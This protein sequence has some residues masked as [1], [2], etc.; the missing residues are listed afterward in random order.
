MTNELLFVN[1]QDLIDIANEIRTQTKTEEKLVFPDDFISAVQKISTSSFNLNVCYES[2]QP[3]DPANNTIWLNPVR[4]VTSWVISA[5]EPTSPNEGDIWIHTMVAGGVEI[6]ILSDNALIIQITKASQYVDNAWN[7]IDMHIY[8]NG[9]WNDM[10][11][12]LIIG[13]DTCDPITGGWESVS[14]QISSVGTA[15]NAPTITIY[16]DRI[17]INQKQSAGGVYRTKQ[18]IDLTGFSSIV[19]DGEVGGV[20]PNTRLYIW[21][22]IGT[23]QQTTDGKYYTLVSGENVISLEV[24]GSCYIGFG[25]Y[26]TDTVTCRSLYLK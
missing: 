19:F 9:E 15:V 4:D 11:T 13:N 2:E 22:R 16:D 3:T 25:F 18:P 23:Y 8:Q 10:I 12:Y 7:D 24:G 5:N 17:H 6:N 1:S 14:Q 26:G 21:P 20:T